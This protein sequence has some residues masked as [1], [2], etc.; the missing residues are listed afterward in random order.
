MELTPTAEQAKLWESST[1]TPFEPPLKTLPTEV[2][3]IVCPRC[4]AINHIPWINND[5]TGVGQKLSS[6]CV[7]CGLFVNSDT[8]T[9]GKFLRDVVSPGV[10]PSVTPCLF[11]RIALLNIEM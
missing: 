9:V 6:V 10:L 2:A 11:L 4:L 5:E 8:L 3:D 7:S 1:S